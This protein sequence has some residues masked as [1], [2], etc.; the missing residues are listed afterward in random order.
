MDSCSQLNSPWEL[1]WGHPGISELKEQNGIPREGGVTKA[2]G[3]AAVFFQES[4]EDN[5][6]EGR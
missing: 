5:S 3:E 1:A 2:V 4:S 6:L